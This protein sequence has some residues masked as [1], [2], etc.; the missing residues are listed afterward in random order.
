[1]RGEKSL[2]WEE[3]NSITGRIYE[4]YDSLMRWIDGRIV[5]FQQSVDITE[6]KLLTKAA[7][8]DELTDLLNRRAGKEAL[9]RLLREAE[10]AGKVIT[11][12]MVD[13]DGL[14]IIN[15]TYG[16]AE[17]DRL[18][19]EAARVLQ[20][21]IAEDE[22]AF[23][24]GGDEFVLVLRMDEESAAERMEAVARSMRE[25]PR[26]SKR[27]LPVTFSYRQRSVSRQPAQRRGREDVSA[28]ASAAYRAG[29]ATAR[30]ADDQRRTVASV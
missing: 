27:N 22:Y 26:W 4:N 10:E 28:E 23:R 8:Y 3:T 17:G 5:H 2:I 18:L 15:D 12:C 20:E 13:I 16:H 11:I 9:A 7:S 19:A 21:N 24:L 25:I 14:K 6:R 30:D 29:A 1:M